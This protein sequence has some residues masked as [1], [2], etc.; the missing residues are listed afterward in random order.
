MGEDMK[1]IYLLIIVCLMLVGC[2][3]GNSP[4]SRVEDLFTKYQK[5]DEDISMG[6]DNVVN[7]QDLTEDHKERY[8][9]LLERQYKNLSYEIKDELVDGDNAT[10]LVE[11]EVVD[12]KKAISDLTFDSDNYT[13][14]SYDEEKLGRLEK[15][16]DKV[17][18]TLEVKVKKDNDGNWKVEALTQEQI[19]KIQGM[20]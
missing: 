8:R 17:K 11:I 15:A 7:Q 12:Y 1:K 9:K 16:Q 6:I 4:T 20:Y 18:Y 19:K 10:V 2:A 5:L 14:E 13:K 3:M